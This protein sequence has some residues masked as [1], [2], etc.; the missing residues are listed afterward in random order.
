MNSSSNS[1]A[2]SP[3]VR[4][5]G[6]TCDESALNAGKPAAVQADTVTKADMEAVKQTGSEA[7]RQTGEQAVHQS[8]VSDKAEAHSDRRRR[9]LYVL[10]PTEL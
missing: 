8:D 6:V 1:T 3:T 4:Q 7:V 5:V 2:N 10:L 9:M